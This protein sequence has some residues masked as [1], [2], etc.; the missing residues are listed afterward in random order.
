MTTLSFRPLLEGKSNAMELYRPFVS[1]GLANFRLVVQELNGTQWK[2]ICCLSQCPNP[3][4]TAPNT[5]NAAGYIELLIDIIADP[6][7]MASKHAERRD[8]VDVLRP[9]LPARYSQGCQS[10]EGVY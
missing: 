9:L 7:D 10:F 5:T 3:P 6:Y 8:V 1:S 2:Y 4:S